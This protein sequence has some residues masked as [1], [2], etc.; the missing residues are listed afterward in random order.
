VLMTLKSRSDPVFVPAVH[1][2]A[3]LKSIECLR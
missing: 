1:S 3:F 2:L